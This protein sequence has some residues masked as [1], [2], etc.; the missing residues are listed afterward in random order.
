MRNPI[1]AS[2]LPYH[3]PTLPLVVVNEGHQLLLAL[4]G[5]GLAPSLAFHL[6]PPLPFGE[7]VEPSLF[8]LHLRLVEGVEVPPALATPAVEEMRQG[9]G[10]EV[11]EDGWTVLTSHYLGLLLDIHGQ[12][13][14]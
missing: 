3:S 8:L 4:K 14:K 2:N 11:E 12:E 9:G 13:A 7:V 1:S 6:L 10:C 5:R